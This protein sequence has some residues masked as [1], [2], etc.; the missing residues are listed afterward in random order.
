MK[1]DLRKILILD[2][3][4]TCDDPKPRWTGEVI[5]IGIVVLDIKNLISEEQ[6]QILVTPT[7]TPITPFCTELTSI[8]PEMVTIENG[9]KS[10]PMAMQWL[11]DIQD[12]LVGKKSRCT[13]ASWGDFDR[14]QLENQ[15]LQEKVK[16]PFGRTHFN[17]KALHAIRRGLTR[18]MGMKE[19]VEYEK[20]EFEGVHHRALSDAINITKV[21]KKIL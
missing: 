13:W 10:F 5:E 8:T 14:I 16:Y 11:S 4:S 3:E 12:N 9:A 21:F 1:S 6:H 18:G 20:L 7:T 15:C 2:L 17:I 19:A